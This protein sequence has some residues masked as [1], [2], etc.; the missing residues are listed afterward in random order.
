MH[1]KYAWMMKNIS[2]RGEKSV[3]DP[4]NG[5]P[6]YIMKSVN[7]AKNGNAAGRSVSTGGGEKKGS[8]SYGSVSYHLKYGTTVER[9]KLYAETEERRRAIVQCVEECKYL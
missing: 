5:W 1:K 8:E 2:I 6:F 7:V 3:Y 4:R 9:Y